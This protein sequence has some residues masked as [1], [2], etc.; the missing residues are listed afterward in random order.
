M[1]IS[2]LNKYNTLYSTYLYSSL[3]YDDANKIC[4]ELNSL[5]SFHQRRPKLAQYFTLN[6]SSSLGN[7]PVLIFIHIYNIPIFAYRLFGSRKVAWSALT[8]PEDP[9]IF[10]SLSFFFSSFFLFSLAGWLFLFLSLFSDHCPAGAFSPFKD[11]TCLQHKDY[12]KNLCVSSSF[13]FS[14]S[15]LFFFFLFKEN[16][17]GLVGREGIR[18]RHQ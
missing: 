13:P 7:E 4:N 5:I 9:T 6:N 15:F 17:S 11:A 3:V 8:W 18:A 1:I 12:W 14:C 16:C 2:C 10:S